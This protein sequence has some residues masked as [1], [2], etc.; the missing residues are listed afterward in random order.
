MNEKELMIL[1]A[2]DDTDDC[3]LFKE[4]L[5]ED[6][7]FKVTFVDVF[8]SILIMMCLFLLVVFVMYCLLVNCLIGKVF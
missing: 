4:A 6:T 1:L 3:L 2:D 5:E 8:N 7:S